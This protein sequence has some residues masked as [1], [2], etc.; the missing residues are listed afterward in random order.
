M[1]VS[2]KQKTKLVTRKSYCLYLYAYC[3]YLYALIWMKSANVESAGGILVIIGS[4]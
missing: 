3:L 1:L 4:D 2:E